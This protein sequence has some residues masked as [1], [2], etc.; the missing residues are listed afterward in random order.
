MTTLSFYAR[1]DGSTA[2][3]A[4][5]NVENTSQQPTVQITFDSGP[6][7]DIVLESNGG[8]PDPDTTVI[9][10]GISYNFKVE[11]TGNLPFANNKVPDPLEGKQITVISVVIAGVTERFYFVTDGSG[12]LAL[13]NAFGNGAI[14]LTNTNLAPPPIFI[15]F[16]AGTEILTPGGYRMVET[17]RVGDLVLNDDGAEKPI[18]WI[19]H[20]VVSVAEMLRNSNLCPIRI[21]ADAVQTGSPFSDLYVSAQHRIVLQHPA[22]DLLFGTPKVLA[23][24]IQLVGTF[25]DWV[26]PTGPVTYY[27]LLLPDHDMVMSNG[28]ATESLQLSFKCFAGMSGDAQ[29]SISEALPDGALHEYFRRPDAFPSLKSHE[30]KI[31]G[32]AM[33][34]GHRNKGTCAESAVEIQAS[35]AA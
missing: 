5:L 13:M 3:N 33:A 29:R 23:A 24:A 12:T 28:L 18:L 35:A 34:P 6:S 27:H 7:G 11:L 25:A 2:N 26:V 30:A 21:A 17:L 15:C 9:I 16:C 4:S 1:G 19:G 22:A 20:T 10:N 32:I 14:P 31:L 8:A